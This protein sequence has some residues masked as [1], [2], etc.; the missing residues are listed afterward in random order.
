MVS[1]LP[2]PA[3]NP[4]DFAV[5]SPKSGN[6][7]VSAIDRRA[8]LTGA[9]ALAAAPAL[10]AVPASGA[11][12][13]AIV[14]AGAAGIAAARRLAAAGKRFALIEAAD[15]S[16]GRCVTDTRLFG[17]PFDR[18]AHWIPVS[19]MNPLAMIAAL[20]E[21]DIY[22]APSNERLRV[23]RRYAP[24]AEMDRFSDAQTRSEQ[25]IREAS[26]GKVDISCAQALPKD[27]GDLRPTI[28]FMLGPFSCA[29]NLSEVSVFDFW[30]SD[31]RERD[32]FC[33]QGFGA[34][35]E[36]L[37]QDLPV[38]LSTPVTE[39]SYLG[40]SAARLE[41]AKGT[42]SAQA[43]IVTVSVGVLA[44]GAIKFQPHLPVRHLEALDKLRLGSYDHI[45]LEIPGNPLGL[46]S[47]D[48]VYEKAVSDRTA[49]LLANV[50]GTSLCL[51]DVGGSFGRALAAQGEAAM[52]DFGI[53]WL[54]DLFGTSIK[55]AV[56][57]RHATRWAQ[58]PWV[59]GAYSSAAPGNQPARGVLAESLNGR[60]WFAGEAVDEGLWGT[61]AGAWESGIRT[62]DAVI[63]RLE[64]S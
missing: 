7:L 50:S 13:V 5:A 31:E 43:V 11:V 23:G 64:P 2:E 10:G 15:H 51:I 34:I 14:G 41:T 9:A 40:R 62:A 28:E 59:R 25:A 17:V 29:K 24:P 4:G 35:L 32:S 30:H 16:G 27:L 37:A 57:R 39:I 53:E 52:I 1:K 56:K 60:I 42:V 6:G 21:F 8:F 47:D 46:R 63:K 54:A 48:L 12:D 22:R 20:S 49:A 26:R 44:A 55:A 58:E 45:A 38:Q 36:R 61:V 33:R 18:G 19:S 3:T